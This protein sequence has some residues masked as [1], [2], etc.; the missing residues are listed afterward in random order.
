LC[1]FDTAFVGSHVCRILRKKYIFDIFDYLSTDA[2]TVFQRLIEK[3]ENKIINHAD[4]T[5]IC[6]EQRKKQIRKCQ[7]SNL[8]VIHN[9]PEDIPIFKKEEG[10]NNKVKIAYVGILQEH[11]LLKEM[12]HAIS[13][14]TDVELHIGGFGKYEKYIKKV[15]KK[16]NNIIYY[17]KLSYDD[18]L[19]L[20]Q[21]CDLMT[22]IYDPLIG[23]HKYAAPNKF[24]E[25]LF[26]GKPL[27]MVKKTG[28]SDIIQ[29]E[30]MGVLI[31]YSEQGFIDG[32]NHLLDIENEWGSMGARMKKL[33]K[34]QYSWYNMEERLLS[35]YK[36]LEN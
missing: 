32:L 2:K 21:S 17:G 3:S 9:S 29:K 6:T 1:D 30:H 22:A 12:V 36:K 35:L 23:I 8:T 26:L 24:Y 14:R 16:Y 18:T 27:I 10:E 25:G 28:L 19:R 7:P 33:Y 31:D 13:S 5:I 4:A 34:E 15:S 11:R 20:E